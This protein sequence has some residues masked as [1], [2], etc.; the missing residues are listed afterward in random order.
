MFAAY[1][2]CCISLLESAKNPLL[3][4]TTTTT[5]IFPI[6]VLHARQT[7]LINIAQCFTLHLHKQVE[8]GRTRVKDHKTNIIQHKND[9]AQKLH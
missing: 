3:S 8:D 6:G 1:A 7:M 5:R 9:E 4:I 2:Y